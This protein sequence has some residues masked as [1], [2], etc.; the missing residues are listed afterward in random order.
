MFPNRVHMERNALSPEPVVNSFI[1]ICHSPQLKY[2]PMKWGKA[3]GHH[4]QATHRQNAYIQSGVA[5]FPKVIIYDTAFTTPMPCKPLAHYL[6]PG[7][8]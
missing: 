4:P 3:Y 7:L 2:P 1:Y 8:G 5:W 6:R